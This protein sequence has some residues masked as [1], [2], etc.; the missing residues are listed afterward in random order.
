[1]L[2][3]KDISREKGESRTIE[4]VKINV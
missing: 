1:M 2:G 4:Y 3:F